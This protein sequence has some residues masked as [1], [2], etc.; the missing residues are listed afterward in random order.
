[1][2]GGVALTERQATG[3]LAAAPGGDQRPPRMSASNRIRRTIKSRALRESPFIIPVVVLVLAFLA[4]PVIAAI[5]LSFTNWQPGLPVSFVGLNNY[6]ALLQ[7]PEFR[8]VLGNVGIYLL[9]VPVWTLV[10]LL[11][12]FLLYERVPG[13]RI[14]RTIYFFPSVLSAAVLGL[15]IDNL[16]QPNGMVNQLLGAVGLRSLE[17]SWLLD[18]ALVK[19][20]IMLVVLWAG[21]GLGVVLFSAALSSVEPSLFEAARLDGAGWFHEIR[22]VTVPSIMP[23]IRLYFLLQVVGVF[24]AFFAWIFVLTQGGPGYT[25][26][27]MDYDIYVRAFQNGYWGEA[28]A[29]AVLLLLVV[30]LIV[31]LW[32]IVGAIHR[33]AL[34]RVASR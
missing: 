8:S 2:A 16:L 14:L 7:D 34:Q 10:P 13:A 28:S 20:V 22:Y 6:S 11:Y 9:G 26:A 17:R 29:E 5:V 33:R 12:S 15:M 25:S 27:T 23:V 32:G 1:M 4:I 31:S 24:V 3:H 18:G 19:P 21:M 30:G